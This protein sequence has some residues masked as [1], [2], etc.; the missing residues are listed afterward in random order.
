[1]T[2]PLIAALRRRGPELG[3]EEF[4]RVEPHRWLTIGPVGRGL[5]RPIRS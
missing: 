1:V 2:L 3:G 5:D 4:A